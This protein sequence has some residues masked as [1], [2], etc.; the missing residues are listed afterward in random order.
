[1]LTYLRRDDRN[2][3]MFLS[4]MNTFLEEVL[5]SFERMKV[6]KTIKTRIKRARTECKKATLEIIE[7]IDKEFYKEL[8]KDS[9][10]YQ[11]LITLKRDAQI[12][13]QKYAKMLQNVVID[14]EQ[15]DDLMEESLNS[16]LNCTKSKEDADK[17]NMKKIYTELQAIPL[18]CENQ[19]CAWQIN[20]EIIDNVRN[21]IK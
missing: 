5:P 18:D 10:R 15:L 14:R 1:M 19:V 9:D 21:K 8:K 3:L 4:C 16:C 6:P 12:E 7:N 2:N 17:C 13:M 20:K 11:V